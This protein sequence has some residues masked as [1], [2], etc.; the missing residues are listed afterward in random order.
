M[1]KKNT[2]IS[3]FERE[4]IDRWENEGGRPCERV[5]DRRPSGIYSSDRRLPRILRAPH[6]RWVHLRWDPRRGAPSR[7]LVGATPASR[8]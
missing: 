4:Q 1:S 8:I 7:H 3:R 6:L 5:V 2:S